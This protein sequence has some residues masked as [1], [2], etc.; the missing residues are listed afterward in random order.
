MR[1]ITFTDGGARGNPG[2]AAAGVVI[3]DED[4]HILD[5]YGEYLGEQTNN[6]AE[7]S[8]LISALKRA[9]EL[10][11]TEVECRLDS[12]LVTKQMLGQYRVKDPGLQKLFMQAYN[13]STA[14]KKISYHHIFRESNKEADKQVNE[15]LDKKNL[16]K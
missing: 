11:A 5:A 14:F 3:K 13:A 6:F 12:E 15:T 2:P 1:V 4:G 9:K 8:A 10:G 16:S 7:Y